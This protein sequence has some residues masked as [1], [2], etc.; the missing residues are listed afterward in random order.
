MELVEA[1]WLVP[2]PGVMRNRL[3]VMVVETNSG[4]SYRGSGVA[5]VVFGQRSVLPLLVVRQRYSETCALLEGTS[6]SI[7]SRSAAHLHVGGSVFVSWFGIR[8]LVVDG[9]YRG[10]CG[11]DCRR[12]WGLVPLFLSL[13]KGKEVHSDL[14]LLFVVAVLPFPSK[15]PFTTSS[16]LMHCELR[17][18][19]V[20]YVK[21][22][23]G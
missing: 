14:C 3:H 10:S 22:M 8:L 23:C 13:S 2:C 12:C 18:R 11:R 21:G 7:E 4:G 9:I 1:V 17:T 6:N 15:K 19:L 5:L 16:E 20:G